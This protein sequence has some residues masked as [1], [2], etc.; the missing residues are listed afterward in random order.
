MAVIT[1]FIRAVVIHTKIVLH[2]WFVVFDAA[3]VVIE[4][5]VAV[6]GIGLCGPTIGD[7]WSLVVWPILVIVLHRVVMLLLIAVVLLLRHI[8]S[9]R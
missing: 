8:T 5:W 2:Y 9:T 7:A 4:S 3:V 6:E 1:L